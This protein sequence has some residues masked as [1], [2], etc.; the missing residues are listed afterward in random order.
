MFKYSSR[1]PGVEPGGDPQ[2]YLRLAIAAAF[3]TG[4]S[5]LYRLSFALYTIITKRSDITGIDW[6]YVLAGAFLSM[7]DPWN[8]GLVRKYFLVLYISIFKTND[9][10]NI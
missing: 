6:A 10:T 7:V 4:M 9:S 3:F 8:G 2:V 5:L 1:C